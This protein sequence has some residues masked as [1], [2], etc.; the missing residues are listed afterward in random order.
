VLVVAVVTP[1]QMS[2]VPLFAL[3]DADFAFLAPGR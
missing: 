2:R 1:L 3:F